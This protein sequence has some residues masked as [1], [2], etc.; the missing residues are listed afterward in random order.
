MIS[1]KEYGVYHGKGDKYIYVSVFMAFG[2]FT[3]IF[4]GWAMIIGVYDWCW[5][6]DLSR[7]LPDLVWA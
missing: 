3:R 2:E 6:W 4:C 5:H 7:Y 1:E